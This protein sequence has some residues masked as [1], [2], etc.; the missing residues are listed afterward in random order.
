MARQLRLAGRAFRYEQVKI[1]YVKPAKKSKYNPDFSITKSDGT[2]MFIETKGRFLTEDRQK[3]LLIR[4]QHPE[5]DI[6]F[7]FQ[8][9]HGKIGKTSKTTYAKWCDDK[10]FKWA[11]KGIIPKAWLDE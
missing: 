8:N 4:Q 5:V 3:H 10:G 1:D 2:E 11:D 7:I 9:A 6:R